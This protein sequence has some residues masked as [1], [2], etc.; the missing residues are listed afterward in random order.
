MMFSKKRFFFSFLVLLF[1]ASYISGQESYKDVKSISIS[2]ADSIFL[3]KNLFLLAEKY[4][5]DAVKAQIVQAKLFN[6]I[7][8]NV[9]QNVY[10]PEKKL[11]FNASTKGET[12][13]SFQR[14]FL[15]AGKRNKLVKLAEL[16]YDKEE[17]NYFDL[18]R[19]L[20]YSLHSGFFNIYYLKQTLI[21][22]DKEINA[23]SKLIM[24]FE[25]QFEKGYVS[26]K[27][28][29]R[30]KSFL[31]SLETESQSYSIQLI[32][33]LSDFNVL[34]HTAN[35]NYTPLVDGNLLKF[36]K[37]DN[38]NLQSLIDTANIHRYDLLMAQSDVIINKA[39]LNYQQALA[40]PDIT[41]A[42]GWDRNGSFVHNFNFISMQIDLP[43]F[44]RNQ[45][46]IKSAMFNVESSK[47]KLLGTKE[48]I[49]ADVNQAYSKVIETDRLYNK[50]DDKYVS[51][52][53]NLVDEMI[54][55]YEKKNIGII[56]FLDYYD[57]YKTNIIQ[58]N[59][60]KNNR[61]NAFENLNFALGK[62]I[63]NK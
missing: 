3:S 29:V 49:K 8:F 32:S 9:S 57:A 15:L 21:L 54:K 1:S 12:A 52:L 13:A 24:V 6:N 44:N 26:K 14:L 37:L 46:N 56:E 28:L 5:V 45:G 16:S 35:I 19:T 40:T 50:F 27:E 38:I 10:D 55:N 41:L 25:K 11:W 2:E 34:L 62:D 7:T 48:R 47:T 60:L 23:L 36:V 31:F 18:I 4:N 51:D 58:I 63:T 39:T 53:D 20:K 59:N 22:Y 30:L 33:N 17:Q 43:V 61:A 42:A